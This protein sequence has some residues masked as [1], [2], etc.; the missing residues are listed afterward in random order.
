MTNQNHTPFT[1]TY[2]GEHLF[3]NG[4]N[5]VGNIL[6]E[7]KKAGINL[8]SVKVYNDQTEE[9]VNIKRNWNV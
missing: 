4:F 7:M 9:Y 2:Q 3:A 6:R 5:E 1:I 8:N